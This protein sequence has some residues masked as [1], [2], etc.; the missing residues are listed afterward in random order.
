[1]NLGIIQSYLF[2]IYVVCRLIFIS[3]FSNR[4]TIVLTEHLGDIIACSSIPE[5]IYLNEN[6][7]V[8][9]VVN[10]KYA[11]VLQNNPFIKSV[12]KIPN[13][14]TWALAERILSKS[15][16]LSKQIYNLHFSGRQCDVTKLKIMDRLSFQNGYNC[17]INPDN[18]YR[19]GCLIEVF[20]KI[21]GLEKISRSPKLYFSKNTNYSELGKYVVVHTTSNETSRNWNEHEWNCLAKYLSENTDLNIVEIGFT[22][23]IKFST[24]RYI[25]MTGHLKFNDIY[26][27]ID[28]SVW[29]IGIDS[30]FAHLANFLEKKSVII[31]GNYRGFKNYMPYS[32]YFSNNEFKTLFRYDGELNNLTFSNLKPFLLLNND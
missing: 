20:S 1:M 23:T 29:F 25:N 10:K 11:V 9:W 21:G 7:K 28:Q 30:S 2:A 4:K 12:I 27:L 24:G 16:R 31:L 22:N 19:Y 26:S 15:L 13:L 32:G 8:N 6:T 17:N 5:E 18:Y 3:F 14:G